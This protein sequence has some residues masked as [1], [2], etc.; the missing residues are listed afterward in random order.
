MDKT[1]FSLDEI[2]SLDE[3]HLESLLI[4]LYKNNSIVIPPL[5][6]KSDIINRLEDEEDIELINDDDKFIKI[7]QELEFN[8]DSIINDS[9]THH[10]VDWIYNTI[11]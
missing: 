6:L 11:E 3:K 7:K 5:L 9:L 2:S 8:L 4:E 10:L 1:S